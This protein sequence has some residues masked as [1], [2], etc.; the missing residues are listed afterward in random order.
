MEYPHFVYKSAID[1]ANTFSEDV[2]FCQKATE[3]GFNIFADKTVVC[4]HIGSHVFR[5]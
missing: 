4:D 3:L 5:V 2:Y 1:H